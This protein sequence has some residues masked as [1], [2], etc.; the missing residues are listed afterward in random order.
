MTL[1]EI[2]L[3]QLAGQH[4]T[5]RADGLTVL[6]DMCGI[7]AQMQSYAEHSLSIRSDGRTE[8]LDT[9]AAKSWTLRGTMHIFAV[10][11]LPLFL[12]EGRT[13]YLRE[14]D[15][16][17]VD[18]NISAE[19]KRYFADSILAMISAGADTRDALKNCCF[20]LGMTEGEA[21]SVFNS[22]GGTIRALCE[23][24]KIC[25]RVQREPAY[26]L[27]PEFTPMPESAAWLELTR[28]YFTHYGP[29]TLRDAAYFFGVPQAKIKSCLTELDPKTTELEGRSYYYIEDKCIELSD[30]PKCLFLGGF[31]PLMLGYE[32]HSSLYLPQ[33]HLRG[34][35]SLAGMVSPA[36]LFDGTVCGKWSRKGK[37]LTISMFAALPEHDRR[38]ISDAAHVQWSD[39]NKVVFA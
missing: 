24:G 15:T 27:C 12:H 37:T 11:D 8:A 7:Q 25:G 19:R 29:A 3:R 13:H 16:L 39:M 31:D 1:E 9:V 20:G 5:D 4:L 36:V 23:S 6:R 38:V 33:E 35:F 14:C 21:A 30:I 28:R 32:K 22:W 34:I 17:G 18:E 2:K 10:S 26:K